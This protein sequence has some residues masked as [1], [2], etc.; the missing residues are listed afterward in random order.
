LGDIGY[1]LRLGGN[2]LK[3]GE[4]GYFGYARHHEHRYYAGDAEAHRRYRKPPLALKTFDTLL[5]KS[6]R[7]VAEQCAKRA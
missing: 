6:D 2:W 5:N 7:A 1:Y 4:I 3:L